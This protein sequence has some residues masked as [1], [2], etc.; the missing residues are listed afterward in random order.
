MTLARSVGGKSRG[1]G[2]GV[3][4][5]GLQALNHD[6]RGSR[7]AHVPDHLELGTFALKY[8]IEALHGLC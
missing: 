6:L 5:I 3:A 4:V 7:V 8:D 1:D 2:D